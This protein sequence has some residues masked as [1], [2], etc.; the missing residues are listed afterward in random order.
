MMLACA[1]AAESVAFILVLLGCHL[2]DLLIFSLKTL[3]CG[4]LPSAWSMSLLTPCLLGALM[5]EICISNLFLLGFKL[6]ISSTLVTVG[7]ELS[8]AM[9]WLPVFV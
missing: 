5:I 6:L 9:P 2:I 8:Q 3:F 7:M 4:R 1:L